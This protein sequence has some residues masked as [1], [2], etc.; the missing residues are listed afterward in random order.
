MNQIGTDNYSI[1][2]EQDGIY[3]DTNSGINKENE[4]YIKTNPLY[5]L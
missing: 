2:I 1:R 4:N 5:Y 3:F